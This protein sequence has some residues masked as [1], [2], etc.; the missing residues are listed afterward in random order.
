MTCGQLHVSVPR[1][2]A[3]V[4]SAVTAGRPCLTQRLPG[5]ANRT[6][7]HP[8]L[9]GACSEASYLEP[10]SRGALGV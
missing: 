8:L 4:T 10:Q 1:F 9:H 2:S 3:R 7:Q 6:R 5:G